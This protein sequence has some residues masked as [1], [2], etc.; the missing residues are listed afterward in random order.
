MRTTDFCLATE[1]G[2]ELAL[3][4]ETAATFPAAPFGSLD[5]EGISVFTP[6]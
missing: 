1:A 2:A 4:V 6:G 5:P 3:P